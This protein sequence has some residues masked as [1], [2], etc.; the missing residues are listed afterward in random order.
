MNSD[1]FFSDVLTFVRGISNTLKRLQTYPLVRILFFF[2]LNLLAT[3]CQ[4][5]SPV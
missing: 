5:L 4:P 2:Y 1:F 3:A